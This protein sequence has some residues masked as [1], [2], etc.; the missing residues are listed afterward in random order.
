MGR[1]D[2]RQGQ[3]AAYSWLDGVTAV[4]ETWKMLQD[5]GNGSFLKEERGSRCIRKARRISEWLGPQSEQARTDSEASG[6]N[7]LRTLSPALCDGCTHQDELL[8]GGLCSSSF[9][10]SL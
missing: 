9:G 3:R 5:H 2:E 8:G 7:M 4:R 6:G 10:S 1:R